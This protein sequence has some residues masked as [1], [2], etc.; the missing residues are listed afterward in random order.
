MTNQAEYY[1]MKGM[2]SEMSTEDQ[3][4]VTE[5]EAAVLA[6]ANQSDAAKIGV[7]MAT[8]KIAASKS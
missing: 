1:V 6:I 2:V 8:M 4:K 7:V 5:A 3:A